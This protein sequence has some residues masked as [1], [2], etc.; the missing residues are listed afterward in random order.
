MN[1]GTCTDRVKSYTCT[2]PAGYTGIH[3]DTG[4]LL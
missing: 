3:C 4:N 2:C 1:G